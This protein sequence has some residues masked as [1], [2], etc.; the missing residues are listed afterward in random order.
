MAIDDGRVVSNF[1]VQSLRNQPITIYGEGTQTRS[2]CY[3][4]DLIDGIWRLMNTEGLTGP[5]H[6]QSPRVHHSGIG[7]DGHFVDRVAVRDSPCRRTTPLN[8]S[9][10]S[11]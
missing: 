4:S 6:R 2:F 3:F 8:A 9:Q 7:G 1:I 5:E 10:T 11:P